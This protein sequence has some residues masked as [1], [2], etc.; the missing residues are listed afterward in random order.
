AVPVAQL[1]F[2]TADHPSTFDMT[3]YIVDELSSDM[4]LGPKLRFLYE[5]TLSGPREHYFSLCVIRLTWL[6]DATGGSDLKEGEGPFEPARVALPA[7]EDPNVFASVQ[8]VPVYPP[9]LGST[10]AGFTPY[11]IWPPESVELLD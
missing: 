10:K 8:S 11:E 4:L 3:V 1:P 7:R 2:A 5:D 9:Y 6:S